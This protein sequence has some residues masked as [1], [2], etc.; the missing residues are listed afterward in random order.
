MSLPSG[1]NWNRLAV[2][3]AAGALPSVDEPRNPYAHRGNSLHAFLADAGNL[4]RDKALERVPEEHRAAAEV[5]DLSALPPSAQEGFAAE[6]ALAIDVRQGTARELGR[7]LER[8]Y[9]GLGPDELPLTLDVLG[10]SKDGESVLVLDY[11][12][13]HKAVPSPRLNWQLRLGALAACLA[14]RRTRAMIAV[15]YVHEDGSAWFDKADL[16]A[17]DLALFTEELRGAVAKVKAAR[18]QVALGQTPNVSP[19]EH[20]RYC[21]AFANCPANGAIIR[22]LAADPERTLKDVTVLLT[23]ETAAVA[24]QRLK[25]IEAAVKH[26]GAALYAYAREN[27]IPLPDGAVLGPVESSRES[28]DGEVAR[29]I[30]KKLHGADVADAAC[31]WS[32]SKKAIRTAI[33]P[34]AEKTGKALAEIEKTALEEIRKAGGVTKTSSVTIKEHMPKS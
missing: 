4:D 25:V 20:C 27:P 21:A 32:T 28:V 10:L 22:R 12:T 2:C 30:L 13:G 31:E 19:G 8:K 9:P 16:D 7:G 1:S 23:P 26:A 18:A 29:Q 24:Y 11:K 17:M 14:Y 6:I 33:R 3:P 5:I 15:V 34:V